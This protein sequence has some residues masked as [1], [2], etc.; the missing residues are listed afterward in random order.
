MKKLLILGAS[1]LVGEAII[2]EFKNEFDLY[3]TYVS[4]LAS[5]PKD[6]QFKLDVQ[7]T[8]RLK[9]IV[10]SIK[11]HI[12]ISCLRGEF[13]QQLEFHKELALEL[14]NIESRLYY[15]ST[16]NVFDGDYS[17]HHSE[18]DLPVA[19]SDYGKFKIVCENTLRETLD[20]R[21]VIV[22]IP[23]IWGKNSPRM[24]LIKESIN[25]NQPIEVYSNLEC[26]NLLDIQL[27][28]QLRFIV[29]NQFK[30]TFHLGSVDMMAHGEFYK[31]IVGVLSPGKNILKFT[32]AMKQEAIF[33]GG[34]FQIVVKFLLRYEVQT[35][36]SFLT[37]Q[38]E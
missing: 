34:L 10:S 17:R 26:N 15:F 22:R 7:Q 38:N 24:T 37:Y 5:L 23:A 14:Q 32:R 8:D 11:P 6:R 33:I 9:E 19:E 13:N 16:A 27:A 36:R 28:K 3:G 21:F 12:V 2:N 25:R 29:E 35:K 18:T 1:G 4:S 20:D 31:R 30:G